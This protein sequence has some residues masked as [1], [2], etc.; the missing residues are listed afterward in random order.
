MVSVVQRR[1]PVCSWHSLGNLQHMSN[2]KPPE[3]LPNLLLLLFL[4]ILLFF[5]HLL[6]SLLLS[7]LLIVRGGGEGFATA[8]PSTPHH[9]QE[10]QLASLPF[11][12]LCCT[13]AAQDLSSGTREQSLL[14]TAPGRRRIPFLDS[15]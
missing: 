8:Q 13:S 9:G 14:G 7:S 6:F 15:S 1:L 12:V 4:Y 3:D 11:L 10:T 5:T 2:H